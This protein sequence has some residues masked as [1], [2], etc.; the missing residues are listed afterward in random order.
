MVGGVDSEIQAGFASLPENLL[1]EVLGEVLDGGFEDKVEYL[2][3][4]I[5]AMVAKVDEALDVVVSTDVLD[6]LTKTQIH[7]SLTTEEQISGVIF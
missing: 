2:S 1:K 7:V 5:V 4:L 3:V 6:V